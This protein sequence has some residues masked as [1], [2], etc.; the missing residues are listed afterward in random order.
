MKHKLVLVLLVMP[1]LFAQPPK[2]PADY[3]ASL[4]D[5]EKITFV[6]GAYAMASRMKTIHQDQVNYQFLRQPGWQEPYF[7]ERFYE[8]I[9]EHIS[10]K[11]GYNLSIITQNIDALYANSDNARI[12]LI[13]AIHI[14]SLAQ[15]GNQERANLLLLKAQRKYSVIPKQ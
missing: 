15:D 4:S 9:D 11:I 6:N 3:W 5:R 14:V 13:Q 1:I 7:V 10:T 2:S 8:I 12:P